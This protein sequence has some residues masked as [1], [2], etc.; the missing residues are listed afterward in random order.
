MALNVT[1]GIMLKFFLK[2]GIKMTPI[3][4]A[5]GNIKEENMQECALKRT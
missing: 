2:T 1:L 5:V 3:Q 4:K